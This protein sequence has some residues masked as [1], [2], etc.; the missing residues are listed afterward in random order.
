[1]YSVDF[2]LKIESMIDKDNLL[3]AV[4]ISKLHELVIAYVD[5]LSWEGQAIG[6]SNATHHNIHIFEFLQGV[7][8]F[9]T[10][11]NTTIWL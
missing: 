1:M 9:I 10:R 8:Q 11:R 5:E 3:G 2:L 7:F 4:Y 6:L